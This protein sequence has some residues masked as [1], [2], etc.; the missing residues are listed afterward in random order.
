VLGLT[1]EQMK[2]VDALF[3]L[4]NEVEKNGEIQS[5]VNQ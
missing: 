5:E 2:E 4:G 1:Q 3:Y